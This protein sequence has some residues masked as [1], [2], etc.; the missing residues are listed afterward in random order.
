[1]QVCRTMSMD[2][3]TALR[4]ERIVKRGVY[5]NFSE[6]NRAGLRLLFQELES[7]NTPPPL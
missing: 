3:E 5:K 4:L 1:M 2:A 6:A 7:G